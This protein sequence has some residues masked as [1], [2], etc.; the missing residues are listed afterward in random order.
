[1][2]S[3]P[4]R[5]WP[6][7][8]F[9]AALILTCGP[10]AEAA[11]E[12]THLSDLPLAAQVQ[13]S[14]VLGRDQARYHALARGEGLRTE[15]REHNLVTDFASSGIKIR[16]GTATWGLALRG[17]GYGDE[18]VTVKAVAPQAEANRVEYR[19]GGLTEWYLNG[20]LG[21]EQGFTLARPPAGKTAEPLTLAFT[22]SG[23][24]IA[25]VDSTGRGVV[26]RR[27]DGKAV[28]R[29]R[30]LTAYDA[31]GRELQ[32]WMQISGDE[33]RLQVD[34]TEAQY[35]L[36]IDPFV[37]QAKLTASD[38]AAI[39]EFGISV[40]VSGDVVVIGA[41]GFASGTGRSAHVFVRPAGGWKEAL[42]ESAKLTASDGTDA[43]GFGQ[44]VAVSGDTIVVGAPGANDARGAA[45]V[46][47]K[48]VGGWR[49]LTESAKLTAS[50]AA[51]LD[52]FGNLVAVDG[53]IIVVAPDANIGQRTVYVFVRPVGG[54]SG[55]PT[56][57]ARLTVSG[58]PRND[59]FG[60]S[61]AVSGDTVVV[62]ASDSL[63]GTT[64]GSAYVFVKPAGGWTGTLTENAMLTPSVGF[65][66]GT[67]GIS[68]G[69]SA[70]TVAVVGF[71][72][73]RTDEESTVTYAFVKPA[74][75]WSGTLTES[76]RLIASDGAFF[77]SVAVWGDIIVAGA[78]SGAA[79]IAD[80]QGSAY[81][82]VR[83]PGGWSGSLSET[84]RLL[85]ADGA[86]N[87]LFG[88]SIAVSGDSIV[89]GASG[90]SN[91]RGAAYVFGNPAP[92]ANAGPDQTA[93]EGAP[94]ALDGSTS[95]GR[96]LTFGWRQLLGPAA[97]LVDPSSPTPSFTAPPLP[98]GF[99]S[100]TLTFELTVT[101][102][103]GS[104]TDTVDV[105]VR[106]VNHAPVADAGDDQGVNEGSLVTLFGVHSFD[107]DGD[108]LTFLWTQTSSGTQVV[109]SGADT[110]SPTFTAPVLPGGAGSVEILSF[111]LTVSDGVLSN[112]AEA[113]VTVEQVN[114]APVADDGDPQTVATGAL[115]ILNA[116]AS[117]DPDGDPLTYLWTQTDG[118]HVELS[119]PTSATPSFVAPDVAGMATLSFRVSVSDG[120]LTTDSAGVAITVTSKNAPPLCHLARAWPPI[121]WPPIHR[122]FPVKIVG[123]TDPDNDR[124]VIKVLS[125]TQDE[126]VNGYADGDTSPDAVI[127]SKWVLVRAE[128]SDKGNG[129]VYQINFTADDGHGGSCT[130]SVKVKVLR[131]WTHPIDDGQHFDSTRP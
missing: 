26:L 126:P 46:F 55:T 122:M 15:N 38:G 67:F 11:P 58:A 84:E 125:V 129:R 29:Y 20:P 108:P 110:E 75:G 4:S 44:S 128:R 114:H 66:N 112:T 111:A 12:S 33:L 60:G 7:A 8:T 96:D 16:V 101:S 92:I 27:P 22:L 83:P 81:V 73:P 103:D 2:R 32:A 76:A 94:V 56:E 85:A 95:S 51:P 25:S 39:T 50:G 54:W 120:Q 117:S 79:G 109:L 6:V 115:V 1:M 104:S 102:A 19:R 59:S 71:V 64:P 21:L 10:D 40:G 68:V 57:T 107:P 124:V 113:R 34:D 74:G 62:G 87:D 130:G 65:E 43:D 77:S 18:L 48:P 30:G 61:L 69:A 36:V 42:T 17:Y 28:L 93:D 88:T 72:K 127:L 63:T 99:G 52:V 116:S 45:Y 123:V 41:M 86:E 89:V 97:E 53:E 105:T 98:G 70:D 24:L 106:N 49:D 121:L 13:I 5:N 80:L 14:A 37:Q 3:R 82:F 100:Q 78:L 47:V 91:D 31:T 35:P 23:H 90:K 119:D 118:P 131:G 9:L